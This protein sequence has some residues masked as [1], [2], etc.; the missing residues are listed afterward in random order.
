MEGVFLHEDAEKCKYGESCERI[1]CMFKHESEIDI[2]NEESKV[3]DNTVH[4]IIVDVHKEEMV[5]VDETFDLNERDVE[6]FVICETIEEVVPVSKLLPFKCKMCD[7]ASACKSDLK[8]H[9]K[10][11]HNWCFIC[12]SSFVSQDKLKDH[13]VKAHS[14]KEGDLDLALG[15]APR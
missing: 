12:F 10:T 4:E 2:N 11:I 15:K 1:L 6:E 3:S 8:N 14:E 5:T 9:K 7:F 13:F